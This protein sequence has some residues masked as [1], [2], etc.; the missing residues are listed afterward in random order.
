MLGL[1][2]SSILHTGTCQSAYFVVQM[3]QQAYVNQLALDGKVARYCDDPAKAIKEIKE[4][5]R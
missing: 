3:E 4:A 1:T 5:L 2:R